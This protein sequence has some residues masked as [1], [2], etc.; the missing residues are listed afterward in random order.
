MQPTGNYPPATPARDWQRI[1]VLVGLLG[2]S[3]TLWAGVAGWIVVPNS[4]GDFFKR[5]FGW[6]ESKIKIKTKNITGTWHANPPKGKNYILLQDG[7]QIA[8][9][10][11]GK[12]TPI[13][14]GTIVNDKVLLT[15]WIDVTD[16][17]RTETRMA[18]LELALLDEETLAGTFKGVKE[19]EYGIIMFK[20]IASG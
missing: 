8:V 7:Q 20:K 6:N 13:G 14:H 5:L 3:L 10:L 15:L 18:Y 11:V 16:G 1:T 12:P 2:V 9:Q 19:A 17:S 4:I